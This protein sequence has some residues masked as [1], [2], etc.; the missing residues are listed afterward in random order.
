MGT[1][2]CVSLQKVTTRQGTRAREVAGSE[3]VHSGPGELQWT[4]LPHCR[5]C[6]VHLVHSSL[7]TLR[8]QNRQA[9]PDHLTASAHTLPVVPLTPVPCWTVAHLL[10][11]DRSCL[12]ALCPCSSKTTLHLKLRPLSFTCCL[13]SNSHLSSPLGWGPAWVISLPGAWNSVCCR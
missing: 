10:R 12:R 11:V 2:P 7:G 8:P 5:E 4:F 6:P 3:T 13:F 9:C 1:G